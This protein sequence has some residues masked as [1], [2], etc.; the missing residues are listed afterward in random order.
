[1][2]EMHMS[3]RSGVMIFLCLGVLI[4]A[5]PAALGA[6]LELD[7]N[8]EAILTQMTLDEK[9]GQMVQ[10]DSDVL[11]DKSDVRK[12]FLG[13]VLSGGSSDP[14]EGNSP[15]SWLRH[16]ESFQ[17]HALQTRLKIPLIY[18]IDAVHGHNNIDGATI[19]YSGRPLIL[20]SVL[21][22]SSAFV[23]A[24]LPCTEGEGIADVLFGDKPFTGKLPR[25][26][27]AS[28]GHLVSGNAATKPLFPFG[29]GLEN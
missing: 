2:L 1:M 18:D 25:V 3:V 12:Y 21:A 11:K 14:A 10:V 5:R 7:S 22:D 29:F 9:I 27:P 13:S 6:N 19:V 15:Q 16:V 26:W 24:W 17:Q 8:I 4:C 23:V 28:D 20:N